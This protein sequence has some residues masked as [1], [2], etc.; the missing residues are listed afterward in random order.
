MQPNVDRIP[1]SHG[2]NLPRPEAFDA[3]LMEGERQREAIVAALPGAVDDVIARQ[4]DCGLD[5]VNDGEY[6]KAAGGG[7]YGSYIFGRLAGYSLEPV[8][9]TQEPKRDISGAR[10]RDE[11]PGFYESGLWYSGSGGPI[12]P[13]FSTPGAPPPVTKEYVCTGPLV[14]TGH[15][16]I[17]ADVAAIVNGLRGRDK[18]GFIAALG[19][20]SLAAGRRNE[21]YPDEESYLVAAAEAMREEYRAITDAGLVVQIDEPEFTTGWQFHPE[22]DV[23]QYRSYL[24]RCVEVINHSIDGLP[25]DQIRI[26]TCWGSG[27]RPHTQDIELRH[28]ADL[29]V[30]IRAQVYAVESSN[31]RHAHEWRVWE[32]VELPEGTKLMPGVVGHATDLVEHPELVAERLLRFASVVGKEHLEAGTDCGIGSRVGHAEVV[33]AKLRALSQGAA[34]ASAE[35]WRRG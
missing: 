33:W 32:D 16:A 1:T 31:V 5:I 34:L 10:D 27:H 15:D 19:P 23:D 11:F 25:R 4:V 29:F 14:Y 30:K 17:A 35:L 18:I 22:F 9:P 24:E 13:G 2:G 6:V 20:L 26:H 8:D 21:H 3:L 7:N 28:I 12:R